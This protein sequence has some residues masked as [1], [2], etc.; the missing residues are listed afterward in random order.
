MIFTHRYIFAQLFGRR[1]SGDR[2][3]PAGLPGAPA[4]LDAARGHVVVVRDD[5]RH[6]PA[7]QRPPA[8]AAPTGI[9]CT[10]PGCQLPPTRSRNGV[11]W[12]APHFDAGEA[13][14]ELEPWNKVRS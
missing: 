13:I 1:S 4:A 10:L 14:F 5:D 8:S 3:V 12:C 2:T 9:S 6:R 7:P 11:D